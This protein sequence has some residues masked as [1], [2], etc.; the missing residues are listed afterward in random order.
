M[1][2][3]DISCYSTTAKTLSI[4]TLS[5]HVREAILYYTV[6]DLMHLTDLSE[7]RHEDLYY[8]HLF[9]GEVY[10]GFHRHAVKLLNRKSEKWPFSQKLTTRHLTVASIFYFK[11]QFQKNEYIFETT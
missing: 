9:S 10:F 1:L 3:S 11:I 2:F 4:F 5:L 6:H 7:N 8:R